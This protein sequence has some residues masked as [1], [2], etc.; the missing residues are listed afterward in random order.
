LA[1]N[2]FLSGSYVINGSALPPAPANVELILLDAA[3]AASYF[4]VDSSSAYFFS[5]AA[6]NMYFILPRTAQSFNR[7]KAE[8]AASAN[9]RM[10]GCKE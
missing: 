7:F 9:A 1:G 2:F 3:T 5:G 6:Q 4:N 8:V 10:Q